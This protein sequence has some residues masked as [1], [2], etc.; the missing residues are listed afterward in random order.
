MNSFILSCST[1]PT[2]IEYLIQLIPLIKCRYKY[3]VINICDDYKRFGKFKI[4]KALLKLCKKDKR[5]VF[6]FIKDYGAINKYIGGFKFM[7]KK[8]IEDCKLI[9]IDDDIL[10]NKELFYELIESKKEYNITC[11]SGFNFFMNGRYNIITGDCD[12]VE[13]YGGVCFNYNQYSKFI[14][15]YTKFYNH[16]NFKNDDLI[17]KYLC[18]SFLG[19]DFIISNV[20]HN[21][22]ATDNGRKYLQPQQYGMGADALHNNK[23]FNTNMGSYHFLQNNIDIL[24][25]F[26]N[27]F[28]LN[29]EILKEYKKEHFD[30]KVCI[31]TWYDENCKEYADITSDINKKYCDREGFEFYKDDIRRVPERTGHW[32]RIPLF[33]ELL[34]KND[35]VVWIDADACFRNHKNK[36]KEIINTYSQYDIFWSYDYPYSNQINSGFIIVKSNDYT[37]SYFTELLR[38]EDTTYFHTPNWDQE[39]INQF[40]NEDRMNI[41]NQSCILSHRLLQD[42]YDINKDSLILHLAGQSKE[43][44]YF[45]PCISSIQYLYI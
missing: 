18:A 29:T 21:K 1:I 44:T 35:Y 41:Q 14:N 19:D 25:T 39:K 40:Y 33:I 3:F 17:N 13:G 27:K 5:I 9:I 2:R 6:Q 31:F 36:L 23:M 12:I 42:F 4:P 26:K 34:K 7:K 20:Y 28:T 16:I 30:K 32:E 10:Y 45:N 43:K 11:G 15:W 38:D 37:I 8:K 24:K 22:Y